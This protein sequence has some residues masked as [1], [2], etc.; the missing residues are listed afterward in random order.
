[1]KLVKKSND[2]IQARY[3]LSKNE[4]RL[5][6][7]LVSK[8]HRDDQDFKY[9][10][11]TYQEL[12]D[13][14]DIS[15]TQV[16]TELQTIAQNLLQK[17]ICF[18]KDNQKLFCNWCSS[19]KFDEETNECSIRFD[20]GLKPY[21]LQLQQYFTSYN[22]EY[23][24]GFTSKHSFRIYEICKQYQKLYQRRVAIA[25]FKLLLNL[26]GKYSVIAMLKKN[27]IR[28]ALADINKYSDL[29]VDVA[30]IKT[31]RKIT[32]IELTIKSKL[33]NCLNEKQESLI[34][35]DN[36]EN[37][38]R[39]EKKNEILERNVKIKKKWDV[40]TKEERSQWPKGFV[41][42]RACSGKK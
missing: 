24:T 5:V 42:F 27:V 1:M 6:L 38:I 32:E 36:Q 9:Y 8:L 3:S 4:Q 19:F 30:Y 15:K 29:I 20:P 40:M 17:P 26:E 11:F 28:P 25:E 13:L 16:Y 7:Y 23:T 33:D 14:T 41:Q 10:K 18:K 2:L 39:D 12:A 31:G 34:V 21:L 35:E 37:I 22:L